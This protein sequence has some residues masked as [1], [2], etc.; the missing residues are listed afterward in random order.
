MND[1]QGP[2]LLNKLYEDTTSD[3]KGAFK[4]GKKARLAG[5]HGIGKTMTVCCILKRVVETGKYDAMYVNL[6]DIIHTM[7]A[8][9][10]EVKTFAREQ[11]LNVDF[12]VIDELDSRFMGTENAA[13]LFGRILEPIVRTRIQ[14]RMPLFICTNS[15]KV[16]ESFSGPL[17]ASLESLMN[18]VSLV[19]VIGGQ[20]A[21]EKVGRGEL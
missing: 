21:R 6:T 20:D 8:S 13:D 15:T 12:L 5:K 11:L 4:A 16:E 17:Q 2:K 3:V 19:P 1:F 18:V 14:N 10:P 7:L 9:P